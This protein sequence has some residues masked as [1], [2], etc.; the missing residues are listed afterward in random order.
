VYRLRLS[1]GAPARYAFPAGVRRGTKARVT[2][3][4]W[5]GGSSSADADGANGTEG[6]VLVP[7]P[8]ADGLLALAAGDGPELTEPEAK[9]AAGGTGAAGAAA[10]APPSAPFAVTGRL[11]GEGEEDAFRFAAKKGDRLA[12]AA[13]AVALG[14]EID[15]VVRVEDESGK[16]LAADDD[17]AGAPGGDAR[18]QWEA[19]ADGVYRVVVA[20]VSRRGGA[21]QVYRVSVAA[22]AAAPSATADAE[23]YR[24][25]PGKSAAVKLSVARP[26]GRPGALVAVATGLPAG[27][28]AT[29]ADVPDKGGELTL[30]LTAAAD[31]KPASGPLRVMLLAADKDGPGAIAATCNLR[32]DNGQELIERGESLWLT[33]LPPPAAEAKPADAAK[34]K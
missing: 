27:V 32:K 29:S 16:V 14:S 26:E 12:V 17:G 13:R 9:S 2:L 21:G 28:T 18:L 10:A 19:G 11:E 34:A 7:A 33:V 6:P 4:D 22:Q 5:A 23:E 31:A 3:F 30:T 15:P 24:V 8:G 1:A 25:A 20:D